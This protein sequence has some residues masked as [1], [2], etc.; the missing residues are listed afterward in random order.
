MSTNPPYCAAHVDQAPKDRKR[1][2]PEDIDTN[3]NSETSKHVKTESTCIPIDQY[4]HHMCL[5][6]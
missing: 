5:A 2:E 3:E 4:H 6:L 1:K